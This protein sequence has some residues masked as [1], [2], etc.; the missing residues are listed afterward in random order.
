MK[1]EFQFGPGRGLLGLLDRAAW[2]TPLGLSCESGQFHYPRIWTV[3]MT[4]KFLPQMHK[5]LRTCP[6]AT[7][8][9]LSEDSASPASRSRTDSL[10][11][12]TGDPL[13]DD[14]EA[15]SD[16]ESFSDGAPVQRPL[17][18]LTMIESAELYFKS[19][20]LPKGRFSPPPGHGVSPSCGV[21]FGKGALDHAMARI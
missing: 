19:V 6:H 18:A 16:P 15:A 3:Q 2:H 5:A 11:S 17:P 4:P 14:D 21:S 12:H 7:C 13:S 20:N 8:F 1:R 9:S 10:S